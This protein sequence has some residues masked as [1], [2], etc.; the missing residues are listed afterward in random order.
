MSVRPG[1]KFGFQSAAENLQL[2]DWCR[3]VQLLIQQMNIQVE[4]GFL[5]SLLAVFKYQ[6]VDEST[7]FDLS[8]Q[9]FQKDLELTKLS[10]MSEARQSR[11]LMQEHLYDYIHLSPIKVFTTHCF[12]S[13]FSARTARFI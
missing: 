5:L 6:T 4:V 12:I 7:D 1:K 2:V 11:L 10:I 8:R 13:H 9:K 3:Y